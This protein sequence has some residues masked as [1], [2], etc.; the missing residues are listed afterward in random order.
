M[1]KIKST[2]D[3][4]SGFS[5]IECLFGMVITMIGLL[6]MAGLIVVGLRFQVES[7]DLTTA[8]SLARAKLEQ[9]HNTSPTS[10]ERARGGSLVTNV[11]NYNDSLSNG[12]YRIRWQVEVYPT[13]AGVPKDTQRIT[14]VIVPDRPDVL[15]PPVQIVSLLQSS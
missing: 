12:R 8:N 10:A 14:V 15:L 5:M 2:T 13:D 3:N 7:R 1:Y 6:A 9:L 4:E 11:T